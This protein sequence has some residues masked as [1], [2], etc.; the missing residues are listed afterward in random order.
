MPNSSHS[1]SIT[2]ILAFRRR[3]KFPCASCINER[4]DPQSPTL[5]EIGFPKPDAGEH[6]PESGWGH[7]QPIDMG[8]LIASFVSPLAS[9]SE[10]NGASGER[11]APPPVN[12]ESADWTPNPPGTTPSIYAYRGP[13]KSDAGWR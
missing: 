8:S 5:Q 7:I 1:K 11:Q 6:L 13:V 2:L 12:T 4:Y 10:E 3:H 9:M